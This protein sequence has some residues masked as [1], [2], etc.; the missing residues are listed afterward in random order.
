SHPARRSSTDSAKPPDGIIQSPGLLVTDSPEALRLGKSLLTG[1]AILASP[2]E[3]HQTAFSSLAA[4]AFEHWIARM[5]TLPWLWIHSRGLDGPW[6]APY[7]YRC[8]MCGDGDP[9]PP[10]ETSPPRAQLKPGSDPP[11][12]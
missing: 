6:D 2:P 11:A 3:P 8:A 10:N 5:D 12:L 9:L 4:Q 7:E 1:D